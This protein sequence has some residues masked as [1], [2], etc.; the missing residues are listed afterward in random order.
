MTSTARQPASNKYRQCVECG[1]P[2]GSERVCKYCGHG[3]NNKRVTYY[4]ELGGNENDE[5]GYTALYKTGT[6]Q[7]EETSRDIFAYSAFGSSTL[8]LDELCEKNS[9]Y[10]F[11]YC[12]QRVLQHQVDFLIEKKG[13]P[14]I[15]RK[16]I[17]DIWLDYV[18][19]IK[20]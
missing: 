12:F 10:A 19:Q 13:F 17:A 6:Q 1:A 2:M 20:L 16:A 7:R 4:L 18:D 15:L 9:G 14:P 5:V 3:T 11:V 8:S